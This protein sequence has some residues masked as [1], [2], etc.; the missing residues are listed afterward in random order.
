[1][2]NRGG[3]PRFGA[4]LRAGETARIVAFGSSVTHDSYYLVPLVPALRAAFPNADADII[5]R[6]L[7]GF[8][9][10]WA[11]H[12]TQSVIALNPDLVIV[13]FAINDHGMEVPELTLKSIEG[14]VRQLR[15]SPSAPDIVFVYFM[16]RLAEALPHQAA[17]IELW[18]R[19]AAHY[20]IPSINAS[21]LAEN[22]V[23]SGRAMWLDRWPGRQS[24]DAKHPMA[25][26]RDLSHQT[27]E[28]GLALG[29]PIARA[30]ASAASQTNDVAAALPAPLFE[31]H[32]AE[33]KAY[34]PSDIPSAGWTRKPVDDTNQTQL[35]VMYFSELLVPE[36]VGASL[37]FEFSGRQLAIW[38]YSSPN[39]VI[40]LD[41]HQ[42]SFNLPDPR[43]AFP[44]FVVRQEHRS[45]H[46]VRIEMRELP[47]EL[48][49]FDVMGDL[50]F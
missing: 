6:S 32:F 45:T 3:L 7:P 20:D 19:V 43:I 31:D 17:V 15:S 10:F 11:V 48:G 9:S 16:S 14:I 21:A 2:T 50:R 23:Q 24:W 28:G 8:M 25:L 4:K 33:A 5:L 34:F 27:Y 49:A 26:T 29:E 46:R 40:A 22:L 42:A 41:G 18:E 37:E 38:G 36:R 12:R 1:M 13:E 44:T 47:C 39:N 35:T 30:I